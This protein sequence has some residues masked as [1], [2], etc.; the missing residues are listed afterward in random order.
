MI[1]R[2]HVST[3]ASL[4]FSFFFLH[5][6]HLPTVPTGN[7]FLCNLPWR[8]EN[9]SIKRRLPWQTGL[10]LDKLSDWAV[11]PLCTACPHFFPFSM[12]FILFFWLSFTSTPPTPPVLPYRLF[13][14]RSQSRRVWRLR[15]LPHATSVSSLP[16]SKGKL[17][18]FCLSYHV[19]R[20]GTF[21]QREKKLINCVNFGC[22]VLNTL[23]WLKSYGIEFLQ[24]RPAPK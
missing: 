13:L 22:G 19:L 8:G 1:H 2:A 7:T 3:C 4:F 12:L 6:S 17:T 23:F 16:S 14:L 24:V 10:V 9:I 15:V 11:L 18:H 5:V 20:L 21:A